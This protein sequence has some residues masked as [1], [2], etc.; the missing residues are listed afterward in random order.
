M[1]RCNLKPPDAR[2]MWWC[3]RCFLYREPLVCVF[4]E[5]FR[6]GTGW[7]VCTSSTFRGKS[8]RKLRRCRYAAHTVRK[9]WLVPPACI[10]AGTRVSRKMWW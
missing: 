7:F 6:E 5:P 4:H 10:F 1:L 3:R 8:V 2:K 9:D